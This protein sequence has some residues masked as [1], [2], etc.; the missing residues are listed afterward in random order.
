MQRIAVFGCGYV[1][2]VTAACFARMGH[3]VAC[4]DTDLTKIR[5]LCAGELPFYEPHLGQLITAQLSCSRLQFVSDVASALKNRNIV[6]IAV[7]TPTA[8]TGEADLTY[9]R[10][11][12]RDIADR[13]ADGIVIVNKS[14]VPVETADL[15]ERVVRERNPE[16]HFSIASNPEFLRE[17][18]AVADFL[19]PDRVVL[20]V[21]DAQT[22]ETLRAL[23]EPLGAPVVVVDLRTAE[24]IKYAANA[25]LATK[26]SFINEIANLCAAVDAAVDGV[27]EGIGYDARIGPSYL[28]PGLGFGGSCLPKDVT[29][30]IHVGRTHGM[31]PTLLDAVMNVNKRQIVVALQLVER[32]TGELYGK[33][34]GVFGV[35][36][37]GGT[38]DLRDSPSITLVEALVTRGATVRIFDA[39]A[40][41]Q[42]ERRFE[43]GTVFCTSP[44]E[45]A[46][47][48]DGVV[49]ANDD[50]YYAQ[51]DWRRIGTSLAAP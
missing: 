45:A 33:T 13:A 5:T 30:L 19:H 12:A 31:E 25:F 48:C 6:F 3:N 20:G 10:Q 24:M 32:L 36:F 29:A 21:R 14:T 28:Q 8:P 35:A 17:G 44:Y 42:A 9:V 47:G 39:H 27:I 23:Y 38:D 7:G 15:V 51:L 50:A 40:N 22:Q 16:L 4:Y 37:K 2:L 43:N 34:I 11:A 18:R 41:A 49:V 46:A 1:G 26:I